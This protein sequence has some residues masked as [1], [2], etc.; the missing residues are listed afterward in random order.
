VR[1]YSQGCG[2]MH[3]TYKQDEFPAERFRPSKFLNYP[4]IYN[5]AWNGLREYAMT[6]NYDRQHNSLGY[7]YL[8]NNDTKVGEQ[9]KPLD[10]DCCY[11]SPAFSYDGSYLTFGFV[12]SGSLATSGMQ[13]Y[14]VPYSDL[15]SG[16]KFDPI[17]LPANLLSSSESQPQPVIFIP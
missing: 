12:N 17:P 6:T 13:L 8:Y 5:F 9:I 16:K 4:V 11:A 15:D 14:A 7:F 1:I 10:S 2:P 3:N